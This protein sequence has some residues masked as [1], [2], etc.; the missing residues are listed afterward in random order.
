MP[1][2]YRP[3]K[4]HRFKKFWI[5]NNPSIRAQITN[6]ILNSMAN[7]LEVWLYVLDIN[8]RVVNEIAQTY[9]IESYAL[10]YYIAFAKQQTSKM[11]NLD[12]FTLFSELE[13]L[14]NKWIKRGLDVNILNE[15]LEKNFFVG[16]IATHILDKES[17]I[18][19]YGWFDYS[20]FDI[21]HFW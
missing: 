16:F 20:H 2:T 4:I 21:S 19:K 3:S 18:Q 14:V 13:N 12:L 11:R 7:I 10:A 1:R 17:E 9:N 15:I 5:K 6:K 8:E